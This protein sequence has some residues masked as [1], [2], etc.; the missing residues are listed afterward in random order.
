MLSK[1]EQKIAMEIL[2]NANVALVSS[3]EP[4]SK[5][6]KA[7]VL[8]DDKTDTVVPTKH[9]LAALVGTCSQYLGLSNEQLLEELE[10]ILSEDEN[11]D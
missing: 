7:T 6:I 2:R 11:H 8:Y 10:D 1:E 9:A 5:R 4:K 3:Y